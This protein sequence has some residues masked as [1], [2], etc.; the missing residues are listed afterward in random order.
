MKTPEQV[1]HSG[2]PGTRQA[3]GHQPVLVADGLEHILARDVH[4]HL[5]NV[6]QVPEVDERGP[7]TRGQD[8]P[9]NKFQHDFPSVTNKHVV[10]ALIILSLLI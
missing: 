8:H 3:G 4:D 5:G 9:I 7:G 6:P 1:Q 10:H 2:H